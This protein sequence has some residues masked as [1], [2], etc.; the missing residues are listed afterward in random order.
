MPLYLFYSSSPYHLYDKI[1][2]KYYPKCYIPFTQ[3]EDL[4]NLGLIY[5]NNNIPTK[6]QGIEIKDEDYK[7]LSQ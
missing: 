6:I 1:S 7:E 3:N 5:Y 2:K 4:D